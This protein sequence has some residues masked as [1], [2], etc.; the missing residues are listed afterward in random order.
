MPGSKILSLICDLN[1]EE[2]PLLHSDV[3]TKYADLYVD[4]LFFKFDQHLVKVIVGVQGTRI[5]RIIVGFRAYVG[6]LTLMHSVME[7]SGSDT[8]N[9]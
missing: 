7:M 1:S 9:T 6:T 2:R 3:N 5:V 4:I 8:E